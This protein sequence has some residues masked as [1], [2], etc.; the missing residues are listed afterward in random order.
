MSSDVSGPQYG[1]TTTEITDEEFARASVPSLSA[2]MK[3]AVDRG[4]IAPV[5]SYADGSYAQKYQ[6]EWSTKVA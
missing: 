5:K 3:A 4:L 1:D 6:A 2:L